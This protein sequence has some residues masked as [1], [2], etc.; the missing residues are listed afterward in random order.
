MARVSANAMT[1]E[2]RKQ[3]TASYPF[4]ATTKNAGEV[5]VGRRDAP[6]PANHA[7]TRHVVESVVEVARIADH[8]DAQTAP[9]KSRTN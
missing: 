5:P 6:G 8:S 1:Q 7:R 3:L 9:S 2:Q 4:A